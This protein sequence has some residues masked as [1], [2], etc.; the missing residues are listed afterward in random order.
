MRGVFWA[1]W[2]V[3][4]GKWVVDGDG[5]RG[6]GELFRLSLDW[7]TRLCKEG[8]PMMTKR[9]SWHRIVKMN[10]CSTHEL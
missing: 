7:E 9:K 4:E 5:R 6:G 8:L 3:S 1:L 2:V 10:Q